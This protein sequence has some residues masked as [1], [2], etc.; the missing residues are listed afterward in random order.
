MSYRFLN[1]LYWGHG[2]WECIN[3]F[4]K[5]LMWELLL[6]VERISAV[7]REESASTHLLYVQ[8]VVVNMQSIRT[9][10][11]FILSIMAIYSVKH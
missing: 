9:R 7:I 10:V 11:M 3:P 2:P 1:P 5:V 4:A 6:G 8:T